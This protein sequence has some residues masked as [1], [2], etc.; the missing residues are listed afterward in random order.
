MDLDPEQERLEDLRNTVLRTLYHRRH[1]AHRVDAIVNIYLPPGTGATRREVE[2]AL[3]DLERFHW[4]ESAF[5]S[6][7]S[8]IKVWQITG[9]GITHVERRGK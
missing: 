8:S 1:G 7:H 2:T 5:E 6:D 3:A 9:T 4:V